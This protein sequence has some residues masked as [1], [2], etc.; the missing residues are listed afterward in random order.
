MREQRENNF[1]ADVFKWFLIWNLLSLLFRG[2]IF[3]CKV[4]FMALEQLVYL[5]A[6]AIGKCVPVVKSKYEQFKIDYTQKYKPKIDSKILQIKKFFSNIFSI[7]KN[8]VVCL[9]TKI[10]GYF[11]NRTKIR[12]EKKQSKS[13]KKLQKQKVHHESN[14]IFNLKKL[15]YWII[16]FFYKYEFQILIIGILGIGIGITFVVLNFVIK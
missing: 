13:V 16:D 3:L 14:F 8:K 7:S 5:T 4:M 2:F 12:K 6:L 11:V 15:K 1:W 9:K 10:T